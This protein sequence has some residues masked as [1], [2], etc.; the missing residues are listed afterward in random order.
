MEKL[1]DFFFTRDSNGSGYVSGRNEERYTHGIDY[2]YYDAFFWLLSNFLV[3]TE[4]M[5]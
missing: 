2:V 4:L 5:R 3:A 1:T